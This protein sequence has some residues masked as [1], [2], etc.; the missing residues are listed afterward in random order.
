MAKRKQHSAEFKAKVALSAIRGDGTLAELAS[1][2]K[3]HPNMITK[4]K[5]EALAGMKHRFARG[6]NARAERLACR[7]RTA[8]TVRLDGAPR[9]ASRG[10]FTA[11]PRGESAPAVNRRGNW[12]PI[13]AL[14]H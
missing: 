8:R 2:Y 11:E 9:A 12:T 3:I 13:S 5:R 6:G 7:P 1:R 4:W 14:S 10:T